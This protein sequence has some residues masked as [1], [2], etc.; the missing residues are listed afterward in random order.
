MGINSL[1]AVMLDSIGAPM[2]DWQMA[3]VAL[4]QE[5][6]VINGYAYQTPDG[7]WHELG[8]DVAD[9]VRDIE[10]IQYLEYASKL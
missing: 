6:P 10:W 3:Q 1:A 4:L 5:V 2:T 8:G 9:A 7:R